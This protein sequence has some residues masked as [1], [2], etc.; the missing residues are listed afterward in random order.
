M[1]P[2]VTSEPLRYQQITRRFREQIIS[3]TLRPGQSLPSITALAPELGY[4]RGTIAKA[5]RVLTDEGLIYQ[6]LGLPYHV[7]GD[8]YQPL[9]PTGKRG[10]SSRAPH[11]RS[12]QPGIAYTWRGPFTNAELNLLHAEGF[13]H[14]VLDDDWQTRLS[15]HS[16]GWVTARDHHGQLTGFANLTWD[17]GVHA[18]LLDTLVT[19][20]ARHAGIGT[21]LVQI[22][23]S[24]AKDA[25]CEWLHVDFEDDLASFYCGSCVSPPSTPGSSP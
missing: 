17:G 11:P 1:D 18:F 25:G 12:G 23:A 2:T 7:R 13:G 5:L 4:A 3:G 9:G 10:S 6:P 22:A 21:A 19:A 16:L 20:T 24:A 8:S 14:P 15:R